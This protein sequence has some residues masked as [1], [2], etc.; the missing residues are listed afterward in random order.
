MRLR[1]GISLF[2]DDERIERDVEARLVDDGQRHAGTRRGRGAGVRRGPHRRRGFDDA[3]THLY[4]TND[5]AAELARRHPKLLFGASVHPYR[6]DA[7][8]ELERCAAA[9][10]VLVKWLPPVQNID[11]TDPRCLPFYDALVR[12]GLPLLCHTG[13]ELSLPIVAP[14]TKD[15]ALLVPAL[16]RGVTVIAAHCGT[17]SH[18]FETGLPADVPQ[19]GPRP[20]PAL[21]RHGGAGR[22]DP[23]LA[24]GP[25]LADP[26]V[27]TKLVHGSDWPIISLPVLKAGVVQAARLLVGE[28]NWL[29]RDVLTKRALGFDDAYWHRAGTLLRLRKE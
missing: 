17:R 13:G 24:F 6:A 20:P 3:N 14:H 23:V 1:L 26:V 12:L 18:P 5:Y 8:A 21:R 28:G 9:G 4:V 2:G 10:A 11:P 25:L 15:P 16:E 29:R 19:H 27:R 7:A 22:P